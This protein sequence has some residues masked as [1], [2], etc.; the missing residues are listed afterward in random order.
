M[1]DPL[2]TAT[3]LEKEIVLLIWEFSFSRCCCREKVDLISVGTSLIPEVF[4][5]IGVPHPNF[6]NNYGLPTP[7]SIKMFGFFVFMLSLTAFCIAGVMGDCSPVGMILFLY[8]MK[9]VLM[10]SI[11]GNY[12][13]DDCSDICANGRFKTSCC[14]SGHYYW[15]ALKSIFTVGY[16]CRFEGD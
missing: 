1:N 16:W 13:D 7:C 2:E 6:G 8:F 4:T 3:A 9:C 10:G 12:C 14:S 11:G 15:V 5:L